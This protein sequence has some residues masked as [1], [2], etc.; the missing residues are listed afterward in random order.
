MTTARH[1]AFAVLVAAAGCGGGSSS[2]RGDAETHDDRGV[3]ESIADRLEQPGPSDTLDAPE[4]EDALVDA[5][6]AGDLTDAALCQQMC[7]GR[8]SFPCPDSGSCLASCL[9]AFDS[10]RCVARYRQLIS[11]LTSAGADA[12]V[13]VNGKTFAD[14][15]VCTAEANAVVSC[16]LAGDA[17]N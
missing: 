14:A 9:H 2:S 11:C 6:D 15:G 5:S 16:L 1:V 12:L 13:C 17:G 7:D 8:V 3:D 4:R 10:G